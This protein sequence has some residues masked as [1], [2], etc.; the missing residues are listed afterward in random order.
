[1]LL[2]EVFPDR[3]HII[4]T[5]EH[6][7]RSLEDR[8]ADRKERRGVADRAKPKR[9][10]KVMQAKWGSNE[11]HEWRSTMNKGKNPKQG[12]QEARRRR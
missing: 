5:V 7:A 11:L 12:G 6:F 1:M 10:A 2:T 9:G 3:A 4:E 8:C